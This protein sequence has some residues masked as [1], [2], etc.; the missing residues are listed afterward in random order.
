MSTSLIEEGVTCIEIPQT[1][2]GLNEATKKLIALV[3]TGDLVHGGH[4]V[5]AHHA[6]C[7][8]TRSDG[9]DLIRPVK[10]DREKDFSR[11]DLL[12]A[13]IDGLARAI[14]FED[15]SVSYTGLRSVG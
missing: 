11:I 1:C 9:N 12:A 13:T 2:P 8:C 6:S 14:V 10:P 7:L 4:P 5:M 3:A 15:K